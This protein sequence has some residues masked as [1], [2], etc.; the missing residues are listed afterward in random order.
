MSQGE[1]LQWAAA[2]KDYQH[3]PAWTQAVPPPEE[4]LYIPYTT[5]DD[6]QLESRTRGAKYLDST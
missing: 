2:P 6:M 5:S 4:M 3:V 1:Q